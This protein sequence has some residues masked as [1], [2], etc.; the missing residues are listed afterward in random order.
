MR[1]QACA[2]KSE[3]ISYVVG[4]Q[5]SVGCDCLEAGD[6]GSEGP[7]VSVNMKEQGKVGR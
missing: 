1:D 6:Y 2:G 4:L 7:Q 5:V 3:R